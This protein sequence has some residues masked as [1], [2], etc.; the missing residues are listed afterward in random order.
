M[1]LKTIISTI[2]VGALSLFMFNTYSQDYGTSSNDTMQLINKKA[3][4]QKRLDSLQN[5]SREADKVKK[6]AKEAS[7]ETKKAVNAEKKA[8]KAREDADKQQKKASE[9]KEKSDK[10]Y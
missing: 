6:D 3:R 1:K 7:S 8:Q 2:A 4:E 10:K 9:A 5:A